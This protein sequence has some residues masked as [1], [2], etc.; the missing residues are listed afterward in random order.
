ML[1]ALIRN[2]HR[3]LIGDCYGADLAVRHFLRSQ[4]YK[5]VTVYTACHLARNNEGCCKEA[6]IKKRKTGFAA[7]R[8]KNI[9]MAGNCNFGIMI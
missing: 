4:G 5:N 1:N 8:K 2:N 7:H 3:I 9:A 6:I